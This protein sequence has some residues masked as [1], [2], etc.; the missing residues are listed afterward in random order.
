MLETEIRSRK[1][2]RLRANGAYGA[3]SPERHNGQ[4]LPPPV[5]TDCLSLLPVE[6]TREKPSATA[7]ESRPLEGVWKKNMHISYLSVT[8]NFPGQF[9]DTDIFSARTLQLLSACLPSSEAALTTL[10]KYQ[11][12]GPGCSLCVRVCVC[13]CVCV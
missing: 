1:L 5:H 3:V 13:A 7:R 6:K 4:A 9:L 11:D 10:R 8:H 12:V 2:P